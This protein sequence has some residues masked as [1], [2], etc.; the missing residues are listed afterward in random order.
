MAIILIFYLGR[1]KLNSR[2]F[3][4]RFGQIYSDLD[5]R[6]RGVK[7]IWHPMSVSMR[8]VALAVTLVSLQRRSYF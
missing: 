8:K 5:I 7:M 2:K 4:S 3:Y 1:K 6:R